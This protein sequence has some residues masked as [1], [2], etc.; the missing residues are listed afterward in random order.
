ME[1]I[2]PNYTARWIYPFPEEP[3]T[4]LLMRKMTDAE[5]NRIYD[6]HKYNPG[7]KGAT[8]TKAAAVLVD[9]IDATVEGWKG[10]T[11]D[12]VELPCTRE[13]KLLM[14][15]QPMQDAEGEKSTVWNVASAKFVAL[16]EA[17]TK[18]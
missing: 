6:R 8:V 10:F 15:E 13:N 4:G 18:N 2:K 11:Q 9:M 14:L 17:D 7:T 3:E 16:Q 5:V 1:L 12:G